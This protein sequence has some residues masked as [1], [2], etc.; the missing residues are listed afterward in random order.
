[1]KVVDT[2]TVTELARMAKKMYGNL[3]KADVDLANQILI[4]DMGM[5]ADGEAYLLEKGSKQKDLWGINLHPDDYGTDDFIEFDSLINIR[6]SQ[7]NA[8]KDILDPEIK[9]QII[10]LVR[11]KVH[12]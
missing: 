6:P 4:V 7:G 9:K 3:V 11:K 8:S 2:I 1:M 12:E 5:H 10:A